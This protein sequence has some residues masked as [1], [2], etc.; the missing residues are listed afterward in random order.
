[1]KLLRDSTCIIRPDDNNTLVA[2]VPA[3]PG[4]HALGDSPEE[5]RQELEDVEVSIARA[6]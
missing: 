1:M 2:Y 6:G 3:I 5:A 4:C